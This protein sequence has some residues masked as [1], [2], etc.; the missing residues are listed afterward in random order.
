MRPEGHRALL[1]AIAAACRS[2]AGPV[3]PLPPSAGLMYCPECGRDRI[4]VL[5]CSPH[6]AG[7]VLL[8]MHCGDCGR[9]W[10]RAASS[11]EARALRAIHATQRRRMEH[12]LDGADAGQL[13]RELDALVRRS[14]SSP[15][16]RNEESR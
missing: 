15:R 14:S 9:G 5:E 4:A 3:L 12:A 6:G 10:Q 2:V 11:S 7:S 8:R 1:S 13:T 16:P